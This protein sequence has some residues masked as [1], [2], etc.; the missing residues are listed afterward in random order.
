MTAGKPGVTPSDWA[1]SSCGGELVHRRNSSRRG[2]LSV[3]GHQW[4]IKAEDI[5]KSRPVL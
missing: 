3:W 2:Y 5:G 4:N 1:P